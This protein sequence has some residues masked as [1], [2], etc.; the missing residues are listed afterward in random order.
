MQSVKVISLARATDRRRAFDS[1]NGHLSFEF[2]DAI[3]GHVLSRADIAST[4]VFEPGLPYTP[5]AYGCAL[6]HLALWDEC[7]RTG[8]PMTVAEDDAIF[9]LD[10]EPQAANVLAQLP[11]DWHLILWGWNFDSILSLALMPGISPAV[12][13][14][15]Q[16]SLR[17]SI[18][19]YRA[20]RDEARAMRLHRCFGTPAYSISPGGAREMRDRIVPLKKFSLRFPGLE[21]YMPNNGI[22]IAMNSVYPALRSYVSLPPLAVTPNDH[23]ISSVQVPRTNRV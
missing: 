12:M 17:E 7:V 15:S 9:R 2:V 14:F 23:A 8:R 18:D 11:E 3:D 4:G 21:R 20:S 5:G 22:D 13:R 1:L 10:F 19:R 16:K 6:S